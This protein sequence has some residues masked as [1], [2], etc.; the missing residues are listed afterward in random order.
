MIDAPIRA[1]FARA[2]AAGR[3][4]FVPYVMA[5]YPDAATSRALALA[6]VASGADVIELGVPF[7]DPLADGATIQHASQAALLGGMT[8]LGS[9]AL[10]HD[11]SQQTDVPLV[12]MGY[13]NPFLR[14]GL[15]AAC[16][17]AAAAG[18]CGLIIPDL[19]AEEAAPLIAAAAPH[20]ITPIF[21]V[22]PTSSPAR[23]AQVAQ[24][25]QEAQSGFIYA[26]SLS[27]VTGARAALAQDLP[28]FLA[29]VRAAAKDI[30]IAVGF[31]IGRPEH[32]AQIAQMA[33]GVV[34]ASALINTY[35]AAPVGQGMAAVA[36]LARELRDAA[37]RRGFAFPS[38]DKMVL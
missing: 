34:V 21:L 1:A 15:E 28:A 27:G 37:V 2:K 11:I 29:Q 25:A 30:P 23:I 4:A 20:G 6:L 13:Y 5:G 14:M 10:A 17:E 22:T 16:S 18:V 19:P 24:A 3:A 36:G 26:V 7:S 9:I 35:D 32:A 12:L 31:G 8:L 38:C 33:D